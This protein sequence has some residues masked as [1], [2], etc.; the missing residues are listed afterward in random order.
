MWARM[1]S[2]A[3]HRRGWGTYEPIGLPSWNLDLPEVRAQA[4]E[5]IE[6]VDPDFVMRAPL[7]GPW[8]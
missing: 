3:A 6:E 4:R 1:V 7:C 5:Y 2:L 8:S